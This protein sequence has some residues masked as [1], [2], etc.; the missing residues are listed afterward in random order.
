MK[1]LYCNRPI[2]NKLLAVSE[3]IAFQKVIMIQEKIKQANRQKLR[4]SALK[5]NPFIM[6]MY[7]NI[8]VKLWLKL[9]RKN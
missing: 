6:K 3:Y 9:Y 7:R 4:M 8:S 1:Q 5:S 2:K